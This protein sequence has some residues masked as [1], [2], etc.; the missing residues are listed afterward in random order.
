MGQR[1]NLI[2]VENGD[3]K[4]Y[5]DHWAANR[6]DQELFWGP[7]IARAFIEQ[8]DEAPDSWLD[9]IWCEGGCVLDFDSRRLTWFGGE[10]VLFSPAYNLA[11]AELMAEQWGDWKVE[12]AYDGIVDLAKRVGVAREEVL[13]GKPFE[14]ECLSLPKTSD[15]GDAFFLYADAVVSYIKEDGRKFSVLAGNFAS[16]AHPELK[17]ETLCGLVDTFSIERF[18]ADVNRDPAWGEF[19]WGADIDFR[20][21]QIRIWHS[22]PYAGVIDRLVH[23]WHEWNVIFTG[24]DFL[25]HADLLPMLPWP[26]AGLEVKMEVLKCLRNGLGQKRDNPIF[27]V[28]SAML[29]KDPGSKI[30]VNPVVMAHRDSPVGNTAW[31]HAI[32]DALEAKLGKD[33]ATK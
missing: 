1:C 24:A 9:E 12:W 16:F 5:Y 7:E 14:P 29:K 3:Y 30:E 17:E 13:S 18:K 28:V 2:I 25:W 4:L 20:Q 23:H 6:L 31:K 11:I 10:N 26:N 27:R 22:D 21:R 8:R 19:R 33:V 15:Q 32:L